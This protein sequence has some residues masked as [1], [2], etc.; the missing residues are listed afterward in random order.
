MT[1]LTQVLPEVQSPFGAQTVSLAG[2]LSMMVAEEFDRAAARLVEENAAVL[3]ILQRAR[4]VFRDAAMEKRLE[5]AMGELPGTDLRVSALPGT[6]L[7][8]SALQSEND[9]LRALLIEVHAA[10]EVAAETDAETLCELIW[11]ELKQST[12]RRHFSGLAG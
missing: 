5:S 4:G 12:R 2:G 9:R 3:E 10:A 6:D 7:R 8:V 11:D 1:L